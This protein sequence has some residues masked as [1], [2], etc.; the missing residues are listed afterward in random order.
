[1]GMLFWKKKRK[2]VK[3]TKRRPGKHIIVSPYVYD[4]LVT[5]ARVEKMFYRDIADEVVILGIVAKFGLT[6]DIFNKRFTKKD[7]TAIDKQSDSK[8]GSSSFTG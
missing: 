8:P 1:M 7:K 4:A 3:S 2:G 5:C 6:R